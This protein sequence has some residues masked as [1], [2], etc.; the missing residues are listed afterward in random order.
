LA[1]I[2]SEEAVDDPSLSS[3]NLRLGLSRATFDRER[4]GRGATAGSRRSAV[5]A[6][7]AGR[8]PWR[9]GPAPMS[10]QSEIC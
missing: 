6:A 5:I 8:R 1:E 2:A 9:S 3:D 4:I 10:Q 7:R